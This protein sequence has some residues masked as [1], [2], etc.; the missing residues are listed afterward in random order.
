[1]GYIFSGISHYYYIQNT[2]AFQ[3]CFI[4]QLSMT[5]QKN[6]HKLGGFNAKGGSVSVCPENIFSGRDKQKIRVRY[7]MFVTSQTPTSI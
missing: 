2:L 4:R 6:L 7:V 1:M 5:K 3:L